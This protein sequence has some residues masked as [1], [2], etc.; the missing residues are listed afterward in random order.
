MEIHNIP[1]LYDEKSRIL[2]LG[3]FPSVKSR[4]GQF[5]Y[6]HPQNRYWKVMA[7]VFHAPV[8]QT[9][10]EKKEMILSH[11]AAM[12]DVIASCDISGSSDSSIKNVVPNDIGRLLAET[13]IQ[14]I[15][16]N[17]G[18]AHK[19]YQKYIKN[20]IGKEDIVLPSTSPANAAWSLERLTAAWR[21]ALDIKDF[22]RAY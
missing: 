14:K 17:G 16:T 19:Y 22:E 6:H 20:K 18:T 1:P 10:A 15:Y 4:E 3:S 9:I 21:E 5:F 2:I 11:H 13:Q 8:P 7:A 12:W